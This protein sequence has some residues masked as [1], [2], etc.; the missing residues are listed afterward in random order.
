MPELPIVAEISNWGAFF[1]GAV[2]I[3]VA[4]AMVPMAWLLDGPRRIA[5]LAF[6]L[7]PLALGLIN[8]GRD[9]GWQLRI[10]QT[11]IALRAP[12]EPFWQSG[13]IA[14]ADLTAVK[15]VNY[16]NR[17]PHY[18][19]S[20]RGQR[21]AELLLASAAHMPPQFIAQLQAVVARLAPQVAGIETLAR[22]FQYARENSSSVIYNSYT[23][24]DGRG[25]LL[26]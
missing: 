4:I 19:L 10:D 17:G 6:A 14:W 12:F 18:V 22:D 21:G 11:G 2:L 1:L 8:A 26:R 3:A 20:I 23:V 13:E 24:R 5:S 16:G 25:V 9:I 7:V 15:I